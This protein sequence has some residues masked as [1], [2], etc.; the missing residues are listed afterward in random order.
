MWFFFALIMIASYTANLAAF[1]TVETLERP[2]ESV[3]DLAAQSDIW[4]GAVR[5]GSTYSFFEKSDDEVYQKLATFMSGIHQ[6]EVMMKN[7]EAGLNKVLEAEGKYAFFMESAQIQ[8][9]QERKCKL[10]QVGGLL[11][12]KGYGIATR[13]GTPYKGMLDQAI[14]KMMEQGVLHRLK[15]KWWKQKRG[16]GACEAEKSGGG[17]KPLGLS[18]VAGVFLVTM[19][20][21]LVA[22]VFAVTEFLYGTRQTAVV[23]GVGWL[24]EIVIELKFILSCIGNTKVKLVSAIKFHVSIIYEPDH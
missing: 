12:S 1:L 24:Q 18:N 17:V 2:I 23:G 16:G 10:S 8:Y 15:V 13:L 6:G 5:G 9:H 20:G 19:L 4:Y 7:N 14:L 21:C 3:E 11:D 22:A